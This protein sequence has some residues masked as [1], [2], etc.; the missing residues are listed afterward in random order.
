MSAV[1]EPVA[2]E[3]PDQLLAR[4]GDLIESAAAVTAATHLGVLDLLRAAPAD[5]A[6]VA[7]HCATALDTTRLLLN[8]L[9]ALGVLERL[10]DGRYATTPEADWCAALAGG[11]SRLDQVVRDGRPLVAADTPAGAAEL[12]PDVVAG[13]AQLCAPAVRRAAELLARVVGNVLDVGAG[14]ATWSIPLAAADPVTAVTALDVPEVLRST[15]RAVEAAGV[16]G[17]FQFRAGDMFTVE[18]PVAAYDLVLLGNVCHLFDPEQNRALLRR[19]RPALR[20]GATLAIIDAL[21]SADPEERR[22]L[23]L[24]ALGLRLRTTAG[25]VYALDAYESWIREAG[26]GEPTV[27]PLS[28]S[29]PLSLLTVPA[30]QRGAPETYIP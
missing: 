22:R 29:P 15:R 25:A 5:A 21:P 19:L 12:Y 18:L 9:D 30:V 3:R 1:L 4:L 14:A 23:S 27:T 13:L 24:Y 17:Q 2:V 11:W 20:P 28:S 16:T 26:Y 6:E 10:S 7:R 8:A